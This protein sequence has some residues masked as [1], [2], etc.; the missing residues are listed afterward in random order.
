MIQS[1]Y[2]SRIWSIERLLH[3]AANT[4][5]GY[6]WA[7]D[8]RRYTS[9]AATAAVSRRCSLAL[10]LQARARLPLVRVLPLPASVSARRP[11]LCES[12]P[13]RVEARDATRRHAGYT[14]LTIQQRSQPDLDR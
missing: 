13:E 11:D 12:Q 5:P 10:G 6:G 9:H 7:G 3:G 14:V 1:P 8:G 2:S 4:E